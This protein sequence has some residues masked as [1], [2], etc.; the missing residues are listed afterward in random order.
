MNKTAL[1]KLVTK[2]VAL[3]RDIAEKNEELKSL[4][5]ALIEQARKHPKQQLPTDSGGTRWTAEGNDGCIARVSFPAATLI[6]EFAGDSDLVAPCK[7]I[8][9]TAF[10]KLFTPVKIYQLVEDFRAEAKAL[11]P[12]TKAAELTTLCENE[13]SPRVS[14]ETAKEKTEGKAK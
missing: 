5:A 1:R 12:E 11:L 8:A 9:G 6:S 13:A 10:A 2:T 3:H 14:F 7:A 4:K